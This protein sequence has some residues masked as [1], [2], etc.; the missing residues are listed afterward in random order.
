MKNIR[1]R[2]T[3]RLKPRLDKCDAYTAK[4]YWDTG[5][6]N[7]MFH[8]LAVRG[9]AEREREKKIIEEQEMKQQ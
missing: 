9:A 5:E 7:Y 3:S 1:K 4:K 8:V 6:E 2:L